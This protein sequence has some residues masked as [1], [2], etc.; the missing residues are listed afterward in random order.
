MRAAALIGALVV[1]HEL[2]PGASLLCGPGDE[3]A[4][5]APIAEIRAPGR[6][7]TVPLQ[8]LDGAAV[9]DRI[10]AGT[11]LGGE[12]AWR[13]P[14]RQV[15]EWDAEVVAVNTVSGHAFLSGPE[16][17]CVVQARIAGRVGAAEPGRGV[18]I[19]GQGLALYCP[20]ARGPSV[21]GRLASTAVAPDGLSASYPESTIVA[22]PTGIDPDAFASGRP[23]N[24]AGLL[25]PGLPK[26]WISGGPGPTPAM[27]AT[28]SG[29][30]TLALVEAVAATTVAETLWAALQALGGCAASLTVDVGNGTGELVV[31]GPLGDFTFDS[32]LVRGF[33]SG[34]IAVG[35]P[36]V[37]SEPIAVRPPGGRLQAG[38]N[39]RVGEVNQALPAFNSEKVLAKSG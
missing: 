22:A 3:L 4:A 27:P 7:R 6:T 12:S 19:S 18:E 38:L 33:G 36:V 32:D 28:E 39:L 26:P 9:G 30:V 8:N 24:L 10:A 11:V 37:G 35:R 23:E 13:R 21:F 31:S 14:R 1:G 29:G 16:L 15:V 25:L 17:R 2:P 34:G 20:L 5:G